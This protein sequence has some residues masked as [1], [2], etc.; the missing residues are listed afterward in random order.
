MIIIPRSLRILVE[1]YIK[2]TDRKKEQ[3]GYFFGTESKFQAFLPAV[4][5][6]ST[7]HREFVKGS[8][9][10]RWAAEFEKMIGIPLV[11]SMHTHPGG[12]VAS[13]GDRKY[14]KAHNLEYEVIIA[15][16]GD[17]FRWFV[18]DRKLREVGVVETD[19]ELERLVFLL[20][21]EVGLIDLGQVFMSPKGE[22]MNTNRLGRA[23][24]SLDSDAVKVYEVSQNYKGWR[25]Q[26]K[27]D[28]R[29]KTGLSHARVTKA[30]TRLRESEL[31]E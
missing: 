22:L 19:E 18:I 14:I 8:H 25:T 13:E 29:E 16:Q 5:Y 4:N 10:S 1:G 9:S 24:L 3:G 17:R 12:A 21:Q 31:I 6:S 30:L 28:I 15:D 20:G 23:V 27:T 26:T 7:P 11:S 2:K